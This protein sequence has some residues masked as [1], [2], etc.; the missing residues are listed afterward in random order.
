MDVDLVANGILE[1]DII[2]V[3]DHYTDI[4]NFEERRCGICIDII[5]DRGF[6]I[7]I[8]TGFVLHVLTTGQ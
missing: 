4:S 5:I 7:S 1:R 8:N 6:L 3:I 2:P